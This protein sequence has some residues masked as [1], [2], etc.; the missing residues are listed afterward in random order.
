MTTINQKK[1]TFQNP[2]ETILERNTFVHTCVYKSTLFQRV[3]I[4]YK[5]CENFIK[6]MNPIINEVWVHN[7]PQA[8]HISLKYFYIGTGITLFEYS[9]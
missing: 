3:T 1:L 6:Q 7:Q 8:S 9:Q 5:S 2:I 4:L